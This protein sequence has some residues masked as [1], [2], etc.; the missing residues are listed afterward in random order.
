MTYGGS[1]NDGA[2]ALVQAADGGFVLAGYTW[3][4]GAGGSD[5][6]LVKTSADGILEWNVTF[7]GAGDDGANCII[8]TNDGGFLLAGYTNSSVPAQSTWLVKTDA[9]GLAEWSRVCPGSAATSL[10]QT[11]DGGYAV[12]VACDNAFGL[13]KVDSSGNLMW[14]QTYAGSDDAAGAESLICT[15][16]GDYALAGWTLTNSTNTYS[17]KLIKTDASGNL[18]WEKTYDKVGIYSVIQTRDGG[19]AMVGDY[20]CLILTDSSG[21]VLQSK[22]YDALSEDVRAKTFTR[23]YC[24]L[25][26]A[27]HQFVIGA[28]QDSYGYYDEGLGSMLIRITGSL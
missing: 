23:A 24:I 5:I 21:N 18:L 25:Q 10:V 12:A 4:Y 20:A 13:V 9:Y 11:S 2:K 8:K 22:Y 28:V 15:T 1:Q 26:I 17:G 19:Y 27:S 6:Y 3:S 16:D 14:N 7:G